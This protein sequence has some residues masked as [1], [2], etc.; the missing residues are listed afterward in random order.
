MFLFFFLFFR[1]RVS[2]YSSGCLGTHFVDQ[3]GLELRN[4]PASASRV[5]GSKVC[6]K[7][8]LGGSIQPNAC[9]SS[10][11]PQGQRLVQSRVTVSLGLQQVLSASST[12]YTAFSSPAVSSMGKPAV[13]APRLH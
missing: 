7:N 10:K 2:L 9:R 11:R 3:A 1:D 4:P 12:L 13:T 5:L 6:A 8:R